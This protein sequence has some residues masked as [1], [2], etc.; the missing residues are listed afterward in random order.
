MNMPKSK[1]IVP[2][3][4]FMYCNSELKLLKQT[5]SEYIMFVKVL[6]LSATHNN[7]LTGT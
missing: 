3:V 2:P 5:I 7:I 4:V 1:P 6:T